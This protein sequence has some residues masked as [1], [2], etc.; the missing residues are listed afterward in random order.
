MEQ[1]IQVNSFY[2]IGIVVQSVAKKLQTFQKYFQIDPE[3]I[4][5]LD[6]DDPNLSPR[7]TET[8][9]EGQALD[10][11]TRVCIFPLGNIEIELLEPIE[12]RGPYYDFLMENGEGLHHFN[13]DVNDVLHF[14]AIM[15][16]FGA[17][18]LTS[19]RWDTLYY[20]YYDA[21]SSLGM[22][23][24]TCVDDSDKSASVPS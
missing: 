17:P 19:G 12:P 6:P 8:T 22:I 20:E 9:Y 16:L 15:E 10:F 7:N 11:Q 1:K 4:L 23:L 5:L 14:T 3:S 2:R 24:E 21:R 18:Q 13:I